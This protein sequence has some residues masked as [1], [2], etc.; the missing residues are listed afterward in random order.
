MNLKTF[1]QAALSTSIAAMVLCTGS[2]YANMG[3]K[4][5]MGMGGKMMDKMTKDL[6]LSKDQSAKMKALHEK[7]AET[8]KALRAKMADDSARLDSMIKA[9]SSDSVLAAA[10][11]EVIADHRLMMDEKMAHQDAMQGILSVTQYAKVL[12]EM[13]DKMHG[14]G[15]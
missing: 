13:C 6:G 1:R 9:K 12:V 11:S 10:T 2:L 14:E 4:G 3:M 15:E 5:H 8:T 7:H